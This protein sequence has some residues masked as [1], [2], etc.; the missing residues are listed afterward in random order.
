M[1]KYAINI[2]VFC[3]VLRQGLTMW[4]AGLGLQSCTTMPSIVCVICV[5]A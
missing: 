2:C 3:F 4:P 5:S 1:N